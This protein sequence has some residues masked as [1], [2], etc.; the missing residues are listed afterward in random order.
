MK[1]EAI[2]FDFDGTLIKGGLDK[3]VHIMYS[4][5][6]AC[7]ECGFRGFL[8]PDKIDVDMDRIVRAFV[9]YPG[10]PRFQ[11]LA[12]IVNSLINDRQRAAEDPAELGIN[13]ELEQR[14]SGVR[15]RY[16]ELFSA[17]N[18]AA[19]EK[20][21]RPF[22]SAKEILSILS[23]EY[24]LYIASGVTQDI[25]EHDFDHHGF[26]RSLFNDILG[27]NMKGGSDKGYILKQIKEKGYTDMLFV[28]DSNKDLEYAAVAGVKF[29]RIREDSDYKR[30]LEALSRGMPDEKKSWSFTQQEMELFYAKTIPLLKRY[31]DGAPMS[32]EAITD[33]INE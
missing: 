6:V 31:I 29:F 10:A 23:T 14:Y 1:A 15:K 18:D 12:A 19:A 7:Y 20:Y 30:L 3:A 16:N 2:A 17:L 32:M 13:K 8:H 9:L 33:L 24:E 4:S 22:P 21:W 11:Q 5:W 25:L 27:A 28:G 26:D